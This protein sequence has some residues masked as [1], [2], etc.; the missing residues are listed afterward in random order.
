MRAEDDAGV[1]RGFIL[2]A[3]T[4]VT[5]GTAVLSEMKRAASR[6]R[7]TIYLWAVFLASLDF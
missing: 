7:D 6:A 4:N 2:P 3:F 1:T 5:R